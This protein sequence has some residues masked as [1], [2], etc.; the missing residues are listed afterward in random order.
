MTLI[1]S[2]IR[3]HKYTTKLT[4]KWIVSCVFV[5]ESKHHWKKANTMSRNNALLEND[6]TY[7]YHYKLGD[8]KYG[9]HQLKHRRSYTL[10]ADSKL[11]F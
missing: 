2:V 11:S 3:S 1:L 10:K 6:L 7:E 8:K 9:H 4:G 5:L